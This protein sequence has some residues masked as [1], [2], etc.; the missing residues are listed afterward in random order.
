M[1]P[2]LDNVIKLFIS[3]EKI[4][5]F[6]LNLSKATTHNVVHV[7]LEAKVPTRSRIHTSMQERKK[8][9][10]TWSTP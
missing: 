9:N 1:V 7:K 3:N 10:S 4:Q 5:S 6:H 8:K 2:V